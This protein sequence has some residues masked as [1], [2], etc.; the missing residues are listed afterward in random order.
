L[1]EHRGRLEK[2]V[3]R[4]RL[5]L[6]EA[7]GQ[8]KRLEHQLNAL[9]AFAQSAWQQEVALRRDQTHQQRLLLDQIASQLREQLGG[10]PH[11]TRLPALRESLSPTNSTTDIPTR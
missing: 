7:R 2:E 3:A 9:L 6:A 1:D 11:G 4:E 5:G 8:T 10:M